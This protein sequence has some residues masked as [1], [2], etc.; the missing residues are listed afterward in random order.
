VDSRCALGGGTTP[1]ETIASL[2]I[3]VAGDA[4]ALHTRFLQND[5]PIVG[6]IQNDHFTV[7]LRTLLEGDLP[8]VA[9]AIRA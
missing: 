3:E 9:A 4:N 6:R 2:A 7:D 1:T 5:P 8:A